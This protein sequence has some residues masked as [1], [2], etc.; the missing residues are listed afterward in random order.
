MR[1]RYC[2]RT[3]IAVCNFRQLRRR[4]SFHCI[5]DGKGIDNACQIQSNGTHCDRQCDGEQPFKNRTLGAD[6]FS[7]HRNRSAI[8]L[9]ILIVEEF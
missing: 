6:R 4:K 8:S 1:H 3:V 9:G 7:D 2:E 5:D